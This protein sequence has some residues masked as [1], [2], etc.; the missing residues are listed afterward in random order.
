MIPITLK[1]GALLEVLARPISFDRRMKFAKLIGYNA[2]PRWGS[3][4]T[5]SVLIEGCPNYYNHTQPL[6]DDGWAL[7][8]FKLVRD[9]DGSDYQPDGDVDLDARVVNG[10]RY[11][12][13]DK[14]ETDEQL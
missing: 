2:A 7:H 3:W 6:I 9:G 13:I 10:P 1:P 5:I 11:D 12:W 4:G 14:D 8:R